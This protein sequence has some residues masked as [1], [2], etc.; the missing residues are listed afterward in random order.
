MAMA[1]MIL[2]KFINSG[3]RLQFQFFK[4]NV[5]LNKMAKYR[6]PIIGQFLL[7]HLFIST[8]ISALL[9]LF[10]TELKW[11]KISLQSLV[12]FFK[13]LFISAAIAAL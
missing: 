13:N 12:I 10:R 8:A 9:S 1:T 4:R 2:R 5:I 11:Q 6:P 3:S 7:K